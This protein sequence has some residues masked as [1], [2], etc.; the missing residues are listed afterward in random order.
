MEIKGVIAFGANQGR[1]DVCQIV[2]TSEVL[3]GAEA[4]GL[5]EQI[6]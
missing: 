5:S 2:P 1:A 6:R 4:F 3:E